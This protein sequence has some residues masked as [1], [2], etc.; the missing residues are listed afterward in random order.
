M[1][2]ISKRKKTFIV[3]YV[4]LVVEFS[5]WVESNNLIPKYDDD[6]TIFFVP[7]YEKKQIRKV[8]WYNCK[9]KEHLKRVIEIANDFRKKKQLKKIIIDKESNVSS[10]NY[11]SMLFH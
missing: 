2:K 6:G 10:V 1:K 4:S 7:K 9:K 5:I 3:F 11:F 8:L